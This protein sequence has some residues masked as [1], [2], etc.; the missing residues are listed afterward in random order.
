ML[1]IERLEAV[2]GGVGLA[3]PALLLVDVSQLDEAA[4]EARFE[5][6]TDYFANRERA[7]SSDPGSY[8]PLP[9]TSLY[10]APG[11]WKTAVER[12]PIHLISH[13]PEPGSPTT[14]DFDVARSIVEAGNSGKYILKP[15]IRTVLTAVGGNIKGFVLPDTVQTAVLA[16]SG[17]DTVASTYTSAGSY[18]IRGI[19]AGT[20]SLHYI[21][22]DTL[23]KKF[24]KDGVTVALG[25]VTTVDTVRLQ[26]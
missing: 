25:Q 19:D 13:F 5:S 8:R 6:I 18:S 2:Q 11:E 3:E 17:T 24:V 26:K 14:L 10:L 12:T 21:P 9:A 7:Q 16:I 1:E 22:V 23:F 4:A 15:V 20:Y